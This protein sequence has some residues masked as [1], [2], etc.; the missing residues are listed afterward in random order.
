MF[1]SKIIVT[2]G[3]G[4]IGSHLVN[5]LINKGFEVLVIDDLSNGNIKNVN[6]KSCF[7][8][9]DILDSNKINKCFKEFSP[10]F[11]VHLAAITSKSQSDTKMVKEVNILGTSN[12]LKTCINNKVKKIVFS[13]SAAV[14]GEAKKLPIRENQKLSPLSPYGISKVK[15]E[16]Q[17]L[18]FS[19]KYNL[20]YSILRY[21]NVYGPKQKYDNEGGVVPIFCNNFSLSKKI[22]VFGNG[23]Q[24]RDFIYV[25]DV[26]KANYLAMM[27]PINFIA[28]VSSNKET[29]ILNLVKN[30]DKISHK[31]TKIIFKSAKKWEID[32][33]C[34]NN[35][36]IRQKIKWKPKVKLKDGINKTYNYLLNAKKYEN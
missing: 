17:I 32:K 7:K 22:V 31:K 26:V 27:S 3:A 19:D 24:T 13:S 14:Y 16:S 35:L 34:L 18:S 5:F 11:V 4:F 28:N 36:L 21:S 20:N 12:I 25:D 2:G 1:K 23:L 9:I 6:P 10:D 8:K 33:S 29:S 30:I 15:A